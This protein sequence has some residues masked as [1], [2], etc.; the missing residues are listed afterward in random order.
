MLMLF[1]TLWWET[2]QNMP[3]LTFDYIPANIEIRNFHVTV[4]AQDLGKF[5]SILKT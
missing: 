4:L 3:L 1:V 5:P 2:R